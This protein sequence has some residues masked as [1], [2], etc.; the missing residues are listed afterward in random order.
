MSIQAVIFDMDG[1]LMDSEGVG[2]ISLMGAKNVLCDS[3]TFV[4]NGPLSHLARLYAHDVADAKSHETAFV[5]NS[6]DI[7]G[8][9]KSSRNHRRSSGC[10]PIT[11]NLVRTLNQ[12]SAV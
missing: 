11:R 12:S 7:N 4:A 3:N 8:P 1:L 10:V 9:L 2:L 5:N 6:F